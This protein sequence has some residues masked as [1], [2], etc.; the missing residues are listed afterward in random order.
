[1]VGQ[2]KKNKFLNLPRFIGGKKAL[3]EFLQINMRYPDKALQERIE[4]SV[5]VEYEIDDNGVVH[6]PQIMKGLGFG[7]DEEALRVVGLMQYEKVKNSGVR[8]KI[9]TKIN[10]HFKIPA[11]GITYTVTPSTTTESVQTHTPATPPVVY[12]YIIKF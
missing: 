3:T 8:L 9:K 10:I 1:M 7:C 11:A 2:K 12:E 5:L 6:N 4:G